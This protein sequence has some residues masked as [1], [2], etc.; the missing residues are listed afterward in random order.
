[1]NNLGVNIYAGLCFFLSLKSPVPR[2]YILSI[3]WSK[4]KNYRKFPWDI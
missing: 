2:V 4:A 1:M 3:P